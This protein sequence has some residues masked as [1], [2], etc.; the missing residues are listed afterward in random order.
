MSRTISAATVSNTYGIFLEW[1]RTELLVWHGIHA[2]VEG[3]FIWQLRP[4]AGVQALWKQHLPS[5]CPLIFFCVKNE[6]LRWDDL[7]DP[8]Q[9]HTQQIFLR[10]GKKKLTKQAGDHDLVEMQR[11]WDQSI[12]HPHFICEE[13]EGQREKVTSKTTQLGSKARV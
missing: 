6:R 1:K 9:F 3:A 11:N 8:F 7:K 2:T 5:A 10:V 13:S 4:G 12:Q